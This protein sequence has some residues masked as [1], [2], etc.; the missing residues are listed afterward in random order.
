MR[1]FPSNAKSQSW[2]VAAKEGLLAD[3]FVLENPKTP[4]LAFKLK[5]DG[6]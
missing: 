5:P 6:E 4:A 1:V 2:A 3:F